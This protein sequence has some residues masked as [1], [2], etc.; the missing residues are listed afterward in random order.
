MTTKK[1]A[2]TTA[3][4]TA[5]A[6]ATAKTTTTVMGGCPFC[7]GGQLEACGSGVR[8]LFG[9][10]LAGWVLTRC[11]GLVRMLN[12][13]CVLVRQIE[14]AE[15]LPDWSRSFAEGQ[16]SGVCDEETEC[17]DRITVDDDTCAGVCH[18][19]DVGS[20]YASSVVPRPYSEGPCTPGK[21]TSRGVSSGVWGRPD[22][23]EQRWRSGCLRLTGNR[24]KFS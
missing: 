23:A 11:L 8:K 9:V 14:V 16:G 20:A 19:A 22:S 18:A 1:Q 13:I 12:P 21:A 6:T 7:G 2:T 15:R 5:T 10:G 3:A 24:N 17:F 4:T